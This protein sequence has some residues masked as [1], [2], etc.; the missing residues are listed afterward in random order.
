MDRVCSAFMALILRLRPFTYSSQGRGASRG[1]RGGSA[2]RGGGAGPSSTQEKPKRE[3]ILDLS[4]YVGTRVK[5]TFTGGRQGL[6]LS[7]DAQKRLVYLCSVVIGELKGFDQLLN[8]VL[9][10]VE[11][12]PSGLVYL[13]HTSHLLSRPLFPQNFSKQDDN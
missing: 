13:C 8:L 7:F 4:K 10:Q 1:A 12:E 3:A 6:R 11:E 9:D 2:K 5:V